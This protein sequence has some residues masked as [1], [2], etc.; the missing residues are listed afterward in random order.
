MMQWHWESLPYEVSK[1][2]LKREGVTKA[3]VSTLFGQYSV[4]S[5]RAN[6]VIGVFPSLEEAKAWALAVSRMEA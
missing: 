5:P 2:A 1:I 3:I 4:F 6:K